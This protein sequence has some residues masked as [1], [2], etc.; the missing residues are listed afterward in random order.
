MQNAK[1]ID[2]LQE[3]SCKC[4]RVSGKIMRRRYVCTIRMEEVSYVQYIHNLHKLLVLYK[5]AS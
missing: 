3:I 5:R 1:L 2:T 4:R